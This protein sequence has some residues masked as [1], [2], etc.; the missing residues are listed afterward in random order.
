M[1]RER[2]LRRTPLEEAKARFLRHPVLAQLTPAEEQPTP[3]ALGRVTAEPVFAARS[4]PH[5][6]CSAMDG[7]AVRAED[8]FGASE[9]APCQ[10]GP[11]EFAVVDTGDPIPEEYDAVIMIEQVEHLPDG[12]VRLIE[13]ARPWQ[14]IRLAGEDTVA[15]EMVAPR[16]HTLRPYDVAALLAAGVR[17]VWVRRKPV[18]GIIPTGDEIV[19]ALDSA[20]PA[21]SGDGLPPGLIVDSNSHLIAGMVTEAG[22]EPHRYPIVPDDPA[23]ITAAFQ[24]AAAACDAVAIIAGSS[25]GRG[26][27]VPSLIAAAGELL[28]HGVDIIPG[29]PMSLGILQGKPVVGVP[30]YPVSAYIVCREFLQPLIHRLLGRPVPQPETVEVTVG[31]RTPSKLGHE[32]FARVKA[33]R[34]GERLVAIPLARGASLMTTLV[35]ADGL[36]RI[37]A[38]SEGLEAGETA[39]LE[40]LKPLQEIENT[41]LAIGSHDI[42][43]DLLADCLKKE[44]P[45][46]SLASAHVG[47]L[48]G[49]TAL[50]RG[51]AHLAGTHLLDEET[52]DY[53]RSYLRRLFPEGGIALITLC[54]RQ[55]GLIVPSG[56]PRNIQGLRDLVERDLVYINRQRGSGTR[57]LLDYE[58][59]R[60]GLE[61]SAIRGYERELFTHLAVASAVASGA[62]D[63][64]LGIVAAARALHLDF[65]PIAEERYDLA[66][67]EKFLE[68]PRVQTLLKLIVQEDFRAAVEKLGGYDLREVGR[69]VV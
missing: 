66:I 15:T 38:T 46:L 13:A 60:Q 33:G 26:D 50:K 34:V 35:R 51:E 11:K 1:E 69:R 55:Q 44:H 4:V 27:L 42:T 29:K 56:N 43:L 8:T 52:G 7:I 31:R 16:G 59:R 12:Q 32:E 23:Q 5:F 58:L 57:I 6:H 14:H 22:G 39:R 18:V 25:A 61:A 45:D 54:H 68:L 28:V 64:G 63:C 2:F 47:S 24:Q 37:P 36:L 10:L 67:P 21:S 41:I 20:G 19:E 48:G 62:A 40:L 53:N 9:V 65:I 17:T 49:L 30:G 3:K